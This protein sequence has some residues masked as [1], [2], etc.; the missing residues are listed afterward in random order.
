[1]RKII[2]YVLLFASF[3]LAQNCNP[4]SDEL[5]TVMK[6]DMWERK[7]ITMLVQN[8]VVCDNGIFYISCAKKN[9]LSLA[10]DMNWHYP[11]CSIY[12]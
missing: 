4:I 2:L 7:H 5:K 11:C 12:L 9:Q 10:V 3:I 1:M 6:D 8:G